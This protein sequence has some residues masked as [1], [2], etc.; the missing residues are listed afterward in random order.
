[1]SSAKWRLFCLGLN[2][3]MDAQ[4]GGDKSNENSAPIRIR[5]MIQTQ[6]SSRSRAKQTRLSKMLRW[7]NYWAL[8]LLIVTLKLQV[9]LQFVTRPPVRALD[10][11]WSMKLRH[12]KTSSN[13]NIFRV[14]GHL[15]GEFTGPRWIPRTKT[16]DAELW[17]FLWYAPE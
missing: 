17:C 4:I 8:R 7:T 13:G 15:C 9:I 1:M 16:S 6:F 3:L 10:T 11:L 2:V 5:Q 12:M 14:T